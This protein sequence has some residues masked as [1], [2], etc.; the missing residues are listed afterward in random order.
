MKYSNIREEALKNKVWADFFAHF[1]TTDI[2]WNIDFC[3]KS[4]Q[5]DLFSW[6]TAPLLWA[7][8]KTWD[9][10]VPE[11]FTQL[12][13]TIWKAKT[14]EKTLAPAFLWAF[15]FKKIAFVEY[16]EIQDIFY[17][18]DFDWTVTPSNH[19]TKEFKKV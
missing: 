17:E 11:M 6:Q 16:L 1:D 8:A 3:V 10:D 9:Y 15:D 12:I 5:V 2:P 19:S 4:K 14:F 18:N 13:L 7:E